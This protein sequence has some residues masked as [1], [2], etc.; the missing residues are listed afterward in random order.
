MRTFKTGWVSV[1]TLFIAATV[2]AQAGI[3]RL[4]P[5]LERPKP[6][7]GASPGDSEILNVPEYT[8]DQDLEMSPSTPTKK[9]LEALTAVKNMKAEE[10]RNQKVG[11]YESYLTERQELTDAM[12]EER[13]ELME[14]IEQDY[15]EQKEL[16]KEQQQAALESAETAAAKQRINKEYKKKYRN[17]GIAKN[18][19]KLAAKYYFSKK[20]K[21]QKND[22]IDRYWEARQRAH[23]RYQEDLRTITSSEEYKTIMNSDDL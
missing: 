21:E 17:L 18:T 14:E 12:P 16:L 10:Y 23:W 20:H 6:K 4:G 13:Q 8:G 2:W 1:V 7:P 15:L 19:E 22:L 3:P 9:Q 5:D 11:L